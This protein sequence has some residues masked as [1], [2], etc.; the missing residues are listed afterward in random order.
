VDQDRQQSY[1]QRKQE[2]GIE[3]RKHFILK[4]TIMCFDLGLRGF[5]LYSEF[6]HPERK[7]L[8]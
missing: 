5:G 4:P 1:R 2:Y 8:P 7:S 6:C 3:K